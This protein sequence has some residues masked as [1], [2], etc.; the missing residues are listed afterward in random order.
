MDKPMDK[1]SGDHQ[2]VKLPFFAS[3]VLLFAIVLAI[4]VT[5]AW[6]TLIGY[7]VWALIQWIAV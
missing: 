2:G 1:S 6:F 5:V 3:I 7:G 4:G